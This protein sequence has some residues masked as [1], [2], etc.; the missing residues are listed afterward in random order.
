MEI[1]YSIINF[2][3]L[4]AIIV[5][6]GRKLIVGIFRSR[7]ERI[8]RE[9]DDAEKPIEKPSLPVAK[10]PDDGDTSVEDAKRSSDEKIKRSEEYTELECRKIML[11][12]AEKEYAE[13]V[14]SFKT[15][16]AEKYRGSMTPDRENARNEKIINDILGKI[17]LTSGDMAYLKHH[18]V[19]YVT[20]TSAYP[21]SEEAVKRTEKAA[22]ELVKSVG[23][24]ISYWVKQDEALIGG[25]CLRIGDTLYD[26]SVAESVYRVTA[27]MGKY[28][29]T[30][31]DN[32]DSIS[33]EL[34]KSVGKLKPEV[35]L[36]QLGRVISVS[37]GICRMDGL[38]DI[39][40]GEIVEFDCGERGMVLDIEKNCIS[41]VIFGNYQHI[42][43]YSRVRRIGEMATV[44]V[45]EELLGRVVNAV[46]DPID[47]KGAVRTDALR[48]IE[49]PAPGIL[50]RESVNRPLHTGIKAIDSMVPIGK[51][52]RELIV[53]DRQTGKSAI[54]IDTIINQ[55]GK[56]IIC[57]YVGIGQK[58][59]AVSEIH[60]T[61]AKH[62]ADKYTVIVAATASESAAMQYTAPFAATAIGEYFMYSGRDVLIVY[63]DLSICS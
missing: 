15:K 54:A 8:L 56:D 22:T 51:G 50:D 35:F 30:E 3:I 10:E 60:E 11:E 14:K 25:V 1:L 40:Y 32:A 43:S 23:G 44:P 27:E 49:F 42:E 16:V 29:L 45:G 2:L 38:A 59:T 55:K 13:I 6:F 46:G 7:R 39:M 20:L 21:L 63:D 48:P 17:R 61:L 36:Y 52:Q 12:K 18:D 5:I 47:G 33:A 53:A 37:D 31:N 58:E 41:C 26:G 34:L 4:A 62:G 9:L 28:K 19:L 57:I 24:R